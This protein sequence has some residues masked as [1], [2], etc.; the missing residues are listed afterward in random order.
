M[1]NEPGRPALVTGRAAN[2]EE[3]AGVVAALL[4]PDAA[5]ITG[6]VINAVGRLRPLGRLSA[7]GGDA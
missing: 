5:N 7:L 1:I 3:A 6:R 2:P 4:T